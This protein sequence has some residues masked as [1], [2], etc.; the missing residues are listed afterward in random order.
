MPHALWTSQCD[1][2]DP[3]WGDLGFGTADRFLFFC[4]STKILLCCLVVFLLSARSFSFPQFIG[5]QAAL[6]ALEH[7]HHCG[8]IS[9]VVLFVCWG[10]FWFCFGCWL[11]LFLVGHPCLDMLDC[12]LVHALFR[13]PNAGTYRTLHNSFRSLWLKLF[14]LKRFSSSYIASLGE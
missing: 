8:V 13:L 11:V 6:L 4:T 12:V 1:L 5:T 2:R 3:G 9:L 14:R 10:V 7:V